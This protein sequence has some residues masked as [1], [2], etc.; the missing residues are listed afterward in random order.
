MKARE[1]KKH[2]LSDSR[3]MK[4]TSELLARTLKQE[5]DFKVRRHRDKLHHGIGYGLFFILMLMDQEAAISLLHYSHSMMKLQCNTLKMQ[6]GIMW[7]SAIL[8]QR[9]VSVVKEGGKC[10]SCQCCPDG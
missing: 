5:R 4:L 9:C 7:D 2:N 8:Y 6:F 1:H 3:S 10:G